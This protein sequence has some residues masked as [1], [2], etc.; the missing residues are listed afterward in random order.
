MSR[1]PLQTIE[2]APE[3]SRPYLDRSLSNN[4]FIP[5]LVAALANAPTALE[6]YL[7]V[8]EINGRSSLSLP[9]REVVQIVAAGIH[10]CEFCVAGHTAIG[11][12][13]AGFDK[14]TV[15][16]LQKRGRTGDQR[17]D[18]VA[19]FTRAVIVSR[20]AVADGELEQFLAA[21]FNRAQ[22]VEVILGVS[23]ATLCNFTNNFAQNEI[24][25]QLQAFRPSVLQGE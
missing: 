3:A 6:T 23:L 24:N 19:D 14:N 25:P 17:L 22:A 11:L 9:E 16:A 20:G 5:N 2:T 18:A 10:G 7:T 13:K 15:I 12:K 1:L 21:G 8:S 4:G